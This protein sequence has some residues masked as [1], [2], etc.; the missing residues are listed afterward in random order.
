MALVES[1]RRPAAIAGFPLS[2]WAFALRIWAAMMVALYAAFWLQLESASSAAVT[3]GILALQTRGQAYQ[4]AVYRILC[5]IIGVVASFAIAGLFDS[6]ASCSCWHSRMARALRLARWFSGWQQGVR[7]RPGRLHRR[8]GRGDADDSP[9]SIS[10][11]RKP[12]RCGRGGNCRPRADQRRVRRPNLHPG[13]SDRLAA[14]Q[15][16]VR[17]LARAI[18]RGESADPIQSA[19]FLSEITALRPNITALAAKSSGGSARGAAARSAAVALVAEVSAAT[20]L[21]SLPAA[22]LSSLRS[23]LAD[24]LGGD[25]RAL[26]LRLRQRADRGDAHAYDALFVRHAQDLLIEDRRAQDAIEDLRAGRDP[27]RDIR[28]P[29]YRSRR[30]AVQNALRAFLAVVISAVLFSLGG[31]PLAAQG[32][33][34]VGVTI[35]LSANTP[36]PGTFAAAAVIAMPIAALLAGVTEFLILDGVDQFPLLAIGMAPTVLAAALLFTIPNPRLAPIGLLLLVFF[37]VML[38]PT[39]PQSYNPETFLFFSFLAITSVILL[40]VLLRT[41]LPASDALRRRWYL[42]SARTEMREVLAGRRSRRLNDE[43]LFR[44]ADRI[45]QLAALQPAADDERRNDLREALEISGQAA[46]VRRARTALAELSA[47]TGGR[48]VGEGYSALVAGDPVD[49]SRAAGDLANATTQ[50]D[51]DGQAAARA[52]GLDLIW[53]AFLID[54]G[55]FGLDS[56]RS[57]SS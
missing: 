29:I 13:L 49:L 42:T 21:A 39:N 26:Q 9:A 32:V 17:T 15:W 36:N 46:A 24:A 3:V 11:R 25:S 44:D 41:L 20:A 54:A 19:N 31:W 6:R 22:A 33:A 51:H 28:A 8:P 16:R 23:T 18:L 27:A 5:T 12:G 38:S 10:S 47:H 4:K 7:R 56:H 45:G 2:A 1:I 34:L 50:L 35:A 14:A 37:P 52:A 40:F 48:L 53:V 55:A 43:A 57:T 30:A